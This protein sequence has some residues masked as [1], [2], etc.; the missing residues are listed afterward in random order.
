M[1]DG[2]RNVVG[3]GFHPDRFR[4]LS[5][6]MGKPKGRRR[7]ETEVMPGGGAQIL[8]RVDAELALDVVNANCRFGQRLSQMTVM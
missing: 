7:R 5:G 4:Q 1:L 8:P 3:I 6:G 2:K